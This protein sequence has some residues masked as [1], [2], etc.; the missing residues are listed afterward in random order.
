MYVYNLILYTVMCYM[1]FGRRSRPV[2]APAPPGPVAG[3]P[4]AD[5]V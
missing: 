2:Q 5:P 4:D 1:S 3:P